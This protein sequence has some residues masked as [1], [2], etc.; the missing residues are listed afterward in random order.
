MVISKAA[1]K[2]VRGSCCPSQ[3]ELR[4]SYVAFSTGRAS[5]LPPPRGPHMLQVSRSLSSLLGDTQAAVLSGPASHCS[6]RGDHSDCSGCVPRPT[7]AEVVCVGSYGHCS[8]WVALTMGRGEQLLTHLLAPQ[9]AS[10][11]LRL[12]L[13]PAHLSP[14]SRHF[15]S[16]HLVGAMN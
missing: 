14:F 3:T 15:P 12:H 13:F 1:F 2:S 9:T 5:G 10:Q 6:I 8:H 7:R 4:A 16:F 11:C